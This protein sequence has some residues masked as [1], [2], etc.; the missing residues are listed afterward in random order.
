[1]N[2]PR[3]GRLHSKRRTRRRLLVAAR[4]LF[5]THGYAATHVT[6]IAAA[7]GYTTGPLG[8]HYPYKH[9]LGHEVAETLTAIALHRIHA[10]R[11]TNRSDLV[12][13][14]SAWAATVISHPGWLWFELELAATG[15]ENRDQ[16]VDRR[17]RIHT[18]LTELLAT[19]IEPAPENDPATTAAS[20]IA[21]LVG[22]TV[23]PLD[24]T[25]ADNQRVRTQ[26]EIL[27]RG[28]TDRPSPDTT[29]P[30]QES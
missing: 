23:C 18:A 17:Q 12:M 1:M 6:E 15:P 7:A 20:L 16:H 13:M 26:I 22:F 11:P 4:R 28:D 10:A 30:A 29:T 25:I 19:T 14:L 21:T 24:D 27:L 2:A 3:P 5:L 8:K 9:L